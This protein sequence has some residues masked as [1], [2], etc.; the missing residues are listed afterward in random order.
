MV[1]AKAK[2][3]APTWNQTTVIQP[4]AITLLIQIPHLLR[5]KHLAIN[6]GDKNCKWKSDE[7]M[8]KKPVGRLHKD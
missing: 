1:V 7:E 3:P 5:T 4:M 2:I 6:R 8:L